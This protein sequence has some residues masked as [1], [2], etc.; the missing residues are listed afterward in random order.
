MS[1]KYQRKK[2]FSIF[3]PEKF[4]LMLYYSI[5]SF[6]VIGVVS[7]LVG[8]IFSKIEKNDLIERSEKYAGYIVNHVN[9]K[10]YE[11][12]F[13]PAMS[14]YGYIDLVNNHD[15]F[16]RLDKV[17]KSNIYGF[18]LNKA[19]LFDMKG[20]IIYSNIS[21]HIGY[22]LD[23]GKNL[24]LDS[25]IEGVPASTL[26]DSGMMD[27]KGVLVEESLLESYY[28]V[29]EYSKGVV[30]KEKQ[31][32]VLEIYQNMNDLDV[33]IKS[34]HRKAVVITGSSM[35]LL[36]LTLL[37]IIKIA[38]NVIRL[39]TDQLVEAR[40]NLENKVDERTQEIKHTYVRLQETQKR[41][42]QSEKLA[43]IGTLAAGVAHEINNPLASVASCAEGLISR[44]DNVDF[45]SKDDKEVF[46]DYLKMI[47]DE[48]YR[49][50]S[51]I[52]K[53]LDFSRRQEPVFGKVD[54]NSL[55][56][57]VVKLLKRQKELEKLNIDLNLNNEPVIIYG[58]NN[59]LKQVAL[60]MIMN[61]IDAIDD[62][63]KIGISTSISGDC[64]QIVFEDTGCGISKENLDKVFE[65]FFST[66][67]PGRG[68]GLGLSICYGIIEE[69]NGKISIS[70]NGVGEGTTFT[71]SLPRYNE[72]GN[73]K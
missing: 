69:H 16:N 66:K 52:F 63:G 62:F 9:L 12:F 37:M 21:E 49:C 59:Q 17:I 36:F 41:L 3:H 18:N 71:I 15:Q 47:C 25:A 67:S 8:E 35:G 13:N 56:S 46:P 51:I 40:D 6:I 43:G 44:V 32:G 53:L 7:F 33:Q 60:N 28:P 45:K 31:V 34:A 27:S 5:T 30:N 54:I 1:N 38:S 61:A 42:S 68:T 14:K 10:M 50:K 29:Y 4:H 20:Q 19:Y 39:K 48:T 64:A 23:R 58:D 65:P 26:Q 57:D 70:S 73:K 11:D 55:I 2:W 22:V 24:Q 72:T